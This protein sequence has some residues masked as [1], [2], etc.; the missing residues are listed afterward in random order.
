M[1]PKDSADFAQ[2]PA[3]RGE[4]H[5]AA[6]DHVIDGGIRQGNCLRGSANPEDASGIRI[7]LSSQLE[8]LR[9]EVEAQIRPGFRCD[10][11]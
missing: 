3:H 5:D 8:G 10:A 7:Q 2:N 11:T 9:A 4:R 1:G 6:A